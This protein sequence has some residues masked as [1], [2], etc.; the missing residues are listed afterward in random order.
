MEE[1][2]NTKL[3]PITLTRKI[4]DIHSGGFSMS[5]EEA[6]G[7]A[8]GGLFIEP[9]ELYELITIH[10]KSFANNLN[11][12]KT[13]ILENNPEYKILAPNV[14]IHTTA[15]VDA[16]V[17]FNT[18]KGVV[19]IEKDAKILPFTYLVGPL[20]IDENVT[21]SP[22][23]HISGSYIGKFCKVGGEIVNS[24]FE[25]Y[26]NKAHTG[27]MYDAYIG[28]W[29][30]IGGGT[31][32]SNL[33]NTYGTIKMAGVET[34]EQFIGCIIADHA[35]TTINVSIYTGK[36]I[37]VGA[38]IYSTVTTDVPNF[39]NYYSKDNTT[40]IPIEVTEKIATRMMERRGIKWSDEDKNLLIKLYKN[41]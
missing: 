16:S 41:E 14:Y 20:R 34:N 12:Y 30:N 31:S 36:V 7:L 35:K 39:V 29:V 15:L 33:K 2:L 21:V 27:G 18:E 9:R 22:H 25:Q 10:K 19:V 4:T 1:A 8:K 11:N 13:K 32:N 6:L 17:V 28:S 24:V 26:S 37:G 23:A 38:H 40:V 5:E 3:Y